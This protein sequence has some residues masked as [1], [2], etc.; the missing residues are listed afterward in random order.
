KWCDEQQ[1]LSLCDLPYSGMRKPRRT[2]RSQSPS[3]SPSPLASLAGRG[4]LPLPTRFACGE[5]ECGRSPLVSLVGRGSVG[6]CPLAGSQ[7]MEWISNILTCGANKRWTVMPA[8]ECDH[9]GEC[10]EPLGRYPFRP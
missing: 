6:A 8:G 10:D 1:A 5:G 2:R 4:V 3:P 7:G 9:A